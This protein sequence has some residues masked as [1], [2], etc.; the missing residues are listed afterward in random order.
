MNLRN[1]VSRMAFPMQSLLSTSPSDAVHFYVSDESL[2]PTGGDRGSVGSDD[3]DWNRTTLRIRST[4]AAPI[5]FKVRTTKASMYFVRPNQ[6]IISPGGTVCVTL[7]IQ[8]SAA[9]G[10]KALFRRCDLQQDESTESAETTGKFM[11]QSRVVG[12]DFAAR[13]SALPAVEQGPRLQQQCRLSDC[14]AASHER[15]H[16]G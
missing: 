8:A 10:M 13:M 7:T 5:A 1:S 12:A 2:H 11:I 14:A 15:C 4:S 9:G 6:G 3:I 16:R